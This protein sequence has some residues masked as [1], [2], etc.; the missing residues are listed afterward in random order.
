MTRPAMHEA[1]LWQHRR[2]PRRDARGRPAAPQRIPLAALTEAIRD[3]TFTSVEKTRLP[4]WT[5]TVDIDG[6]A[7]GLLAYDIDNNTPLPHPQDEI[8]GLILSARSPG[9]NGLHIILAVENLRHRSS[10]HYAAAHNHAAHASGLAQWAQRHDAT[11]QDRRD[12]HGVLHIESDPTA[13]WTPDV[14]PLHWDP[15]IPSAAAATPHRPPPTHQPDTE[16][17]DALMSIRCDD[18]SD[19]LA[20]MAAAAAALNDGKLTEA[21]ID[22][23]C[24]IAGGGHYNPAENQRTLDELRRSTRQHTAGSI[25]TRAAARGWQPPGTDTAQSAVRQLLAKLPTPPTTHPNPEAHTDTH[26][27]VTTITPTQPPPPPPP[28]AL[29]IPGGTHLIAVGQINILIA[30]FGIGK[31]WI[32]LEAAIRW[33]KHH[34]DA[35]IILFAEDSPRDIHRRLITLNWTERSKNDTQLHI[36]DAHHWT[37]IANPTEQTALQLSTHIHTLIDD[38]K[39]PPLIILDTLKA[40]GWAHDGEHND[41]P[42]ALGHSIIRRQTRHG[43]TPTILAAGHPR[44]NNP[45]GT[46]SGSNVTFGAIKGIAWSMKGQMPERD[47]DSSTL[48]L[49]REKDTAALAA[50]TLTVTVTRT[51]A[52]PQDRHADAQPDRLALTIAPSTHTADTTDPYVAAILATLADAASPIDATEI[53]RRIKADE[54]TSL[55]PGRNTIIGRLRQMLDTGLVEQPGGLWAIRNKNTADTDDH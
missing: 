48:T 16:L 26:P 25:I 50:S 55:R 22:S 33:Q 51:A 11:W 24:R 43:H 14:E 1:L 52:D 21:D 37:Q 39:D 40:C 20:V 18:R 54:T 28:A 34:P 30:R 32:I 38:S 10:A 35:A 49:R 4:V 41:P 45:D 8:P 12:L 19:W 15:D 17:H 29:P 6:A 23:W 42:L 44:K 5:C 7:T 53:G 46:L 27:A 3:E 13:I 36:T 47:E 2:I 31:T 9:G